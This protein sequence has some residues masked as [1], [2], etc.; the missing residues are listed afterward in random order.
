MQ[1]VKFS[2]SVSNPSE[3]F[4][5]F[6]VIDVESFKNLDADVK[7]QCELEEFDAKS[8]QI[9]F[10]SKVENCVKEFVFGSELNVEQSDLV[11]EKIGASIADIAA[12]LKTKN[13]VI[14]IKLHSGL[15]A[16]KKNEI[17]SKIYFGFMQKIYRF[18]KYLT[19]EKFTKKLPSV[20]QVV[21]LVDA[22][23]QVQS[24]N[25]RVL[26]IDYILNSIYLVRDLV[27]EPANV[28]Y[29]ET[30]VQ[31]AQKE[32]G[33]LP[34]KIKV[35]S[36]K[37]LEAMGANLI[38]GVGKASDKEAKMLI[39]EYHGNSLENTTKLAL[40]G[41]G[42]TFDSGGMSLK[43]SEGMEDMKGDMAGAA[44]VL[45]VVK[46]LALRKAKVNV[47]GLMGLVENMV[48]ANAQKPGDIVKSLSGQTVEVL[49]TDAE[50]RLVLGDVLHYAQ[51][52][53]KPEY[54]V[55]LATLT[56][57]IV[58]ALGYYMAGMYS[59]S[60]IFAQQ[61]IESGK[62]TGDLCWRM[63]LGDYYDKMINS[64]IADMKNIS[65]TR[66]AG[67]ITGAVFLQR[68]IGEN[69]NWIHLDI[70]GTSDNNKDQDLY[71]AGGSGFGVKLL[72]NLIAKNLEAK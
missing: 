69:K 16:E 68:F 66:T 10:T 30:F 5:L 50:G 41:K 34:V 13:N 58:V 54:M 24:V 14:A 44:T 55:D 42:V 35:I 70:A 59:N 72:N 18:G 48:D 23:E 20:I 22:N 4:Y 32:L 29:P 67:S 62:E 17:L 40:V 21:L 6:H 46:L 26:E 71:V 3:K 12:R 43:P 8:G 60:D 11:V 49:N 39:V 36:Q 52:H 53:Y 57:A 7:K 63:P 45:G 27:N 9:S 37:E 64:S 25:K 2:C 33:N 65:G 47:V 51:T 61:M 31:I 38:V 19:Q 56:G 1:S 15:D 28:V